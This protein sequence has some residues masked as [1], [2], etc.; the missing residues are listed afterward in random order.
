MSVKSFSVIRVV[1]PSFSDSLREDTIF[2][3]DRL[4]KSVCIVIPFRSSLSGANSMSVS[5]LTSG[6]LMK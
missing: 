1:Y 3:E 5:P 6:F 2:D 4:S